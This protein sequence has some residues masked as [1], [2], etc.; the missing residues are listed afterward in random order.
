MIA[1][2]AVLPAVKPPRLHAIPGDVTQ[3]PWVGVAA[4][5]EAPLDEK[6]SERITWEIV[7]LPLLVTV[8]R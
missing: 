1:R 8:I 7:E 5:T 3:V 2:T 6:A 4:K